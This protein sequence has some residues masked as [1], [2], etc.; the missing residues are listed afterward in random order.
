MEN[1]KDNLF[2]G[3][4][5]DGFHGLL[6]FLPI[7]VLGTLESVAHLY[8][9]AIGVLQIGIVHEENLITF[10][11]GYAKAQA[12]QQEKDVSVHFSFY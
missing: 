2:L 11:A 4:H 3:S 1:E 10:C 5:I 12:K 6:F 9:L 7:D 8:H